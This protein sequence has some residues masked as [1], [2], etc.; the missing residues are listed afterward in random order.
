[1]QTVKLPRLTIIA[2]AVLRER[3]V[4]ELLAAGATG[5]TSWLVDG[6]GSRHLRSGDLPGENI[7]IE[8]IASPDVA[9]QILAKLSSEYFPHFALIAYVSDVWV[10]RGDKY[11]N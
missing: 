5:Y 11:V 8:T 2:E 10:V 6:E 9:E 4:D 3:L 7:L 1:M